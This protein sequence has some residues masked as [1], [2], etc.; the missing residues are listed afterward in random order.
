MEGVSDVALLRMY[1]AFDSIEEITQTSK[2]HSKTTGRI[3]LGV[4]QIRN[5]SRGL[6]LP[7]S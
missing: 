3:I 4:V 1:Y 6:H 7:D 5:S 2:T